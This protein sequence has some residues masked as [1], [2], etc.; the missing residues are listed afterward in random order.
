MIRNFFTNDIDASKLFVRSFG[1]RTGISASRGVRINAFALT[2]ID[3]PLN[4][5]GV[6]NPG[7]SE[8]RIGGAPMGRMGASTSRIGRALPRIGRR[9]LARRVNCVG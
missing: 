6:G 3:A 7:M 9:E 5:F 4:R 1:C 2:N 8:Q